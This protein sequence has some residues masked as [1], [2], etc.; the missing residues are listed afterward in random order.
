MRVV[1]NAYLFRDT[2]LELVKADRVEYEAIIAN[3][4]DDRS[5]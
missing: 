5:G 3:S 4:R 2:M 1:P